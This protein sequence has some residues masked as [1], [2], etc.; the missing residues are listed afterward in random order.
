MGLEAAENKVNQKISKINR[1]I[2]A[3][4]LLLN[5][6]KDEKY[7]DQVK[8]IKQLYREI[9]S[10]ERNLSKIYDFKKRYGLQIKTP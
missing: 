9:E 7:K 10:E 8:K 2:F 4:T 3:N 1:D 6:L 5:Q